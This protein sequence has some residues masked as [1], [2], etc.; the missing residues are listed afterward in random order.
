MWDYRCGCGWAVLSARS[1]FEETTLSTSK[2]RKIK[3]RN[4]E[5]S[6]HCSRLHHVCDPASATPCQENNEGGVSRNLQEISQRHPI[7]V[8]IS[9]YPIRV[10]FEHF[11]SSRFSMP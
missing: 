3:F 10:D 2:I 11:D 6:S 1:G 5:F 9:T 7:R 8:E 4:F